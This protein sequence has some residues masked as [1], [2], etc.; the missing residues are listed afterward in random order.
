[1]KKDLAMKKVKQP[2][3][4]PHHLKSHCQRVNCKSSVWLRRH[5]DMDHQP[6]I[7]WLCT[8]GRV[9]PTDIPTQT[10]MTKAPRP[11]RS[12]LY[13]VRPWPPWTHH[14]SAPD[15][16]QPFH[17]ERHSAFRAVT[18]LNDQIC[19]WEVNI[20]MADQICSCYSCR[21]LKVSLWCSQPG[22]DWQPGVPDAILVIGCRKAPPLSGEAKSPFYQ[23]KHWGAPLHLL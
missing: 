19:C 8:N 9:Q 1:M 7:R 15:H 14:C 23:G 12:T 20:T 18:F 21:G 2:G 3:R 17:Q 10:K 5:A 4:L 11:S 13:P 22:L 6:T 16:H